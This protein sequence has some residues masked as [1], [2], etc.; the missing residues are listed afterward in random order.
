MHKLKKTKKIKTRF[1]V[2]FLKKNKFLFFANRH[3]T[4]QL[5][6]FRWQEKNESLT[7]RNILRHDESAD[8]EV[9]VATEIVESLI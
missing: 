2:K 7:E 5:L 1:P 6:I 9:P 4:I 3:F 8:K